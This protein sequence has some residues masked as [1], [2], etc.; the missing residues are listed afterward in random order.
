[1]IRTD[2]RR[3]VAEPCTGYRDRDSGT[4]QH[5]GPT[6][7]IHE[8]G[9]DEPFPVDP[10]CPENPALDEPLIATV[11]NMR[12]FEDRRDV[13][14]YDANTGARFSATPGD[15]FQLADT[16]PLIGT[17]D[18]PLILAVERCTIHPARV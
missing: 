2:G 9:K 18:Q 7:P 10:H 15:Y 4:L 5:D 14:V 6:C 1:M 11:A 8:N 17:D 16:D 13:F 3:T 12:L